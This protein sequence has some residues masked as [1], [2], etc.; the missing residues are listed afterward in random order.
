MQGNN[1]YREKEIIASVTKGEVGSFRILFDRYRN[2]IFT[3]CLKITKTKE[4]AEEIVQDVFLR[5]WQNRSKLD[6]EL[7]IKPYLCTI[8]KNLAFNF[9]KKAANDEKLKREVFF[10][11]P[12]EFRLEDQLDYNDTKL[13]ID[14]AIEKMPEGQRKVFLMSRKGNQSND[15]IAINLSV[16]K[17]TVKDQLFKALR[18]LRQYLATSQ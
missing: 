10:V 11:S 13:L 15:E 1:L 16:S 12:K 4:A 9:L 5:I 3:Y 17:N 14:R 7:P 2:E 18:H 8:T 6:P